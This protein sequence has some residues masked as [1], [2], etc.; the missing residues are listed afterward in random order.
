MDELRRSQVAIV[1]KQFKGQAVSNELLE[2]FCQS[3]KIE[4]MILKGELSDY[5]AQMEHDEMIQRLLPKLLATLQ[6]YQYVPEYA[7]EAERKAL[8]KAN[9]DLRIE[10]AELIEEQ[11]IPYRFVSIIGDE[12]GNDIGQMIKSA[13]TTIF[14][15]TL[16]VMIHIAREKF[17]E[18]FNT[19]HSRDYAQK[20]YDDADNKAKEE[21]K[22]VDNEG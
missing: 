8:N 3:N 14:N 2:K 15:K 18:E 21:E 10:L 7:P 13:G 16:E 17:G 4:P 12:L 1:A 22:P 20:I 5:T 6:K 11:A 9:N 19:K